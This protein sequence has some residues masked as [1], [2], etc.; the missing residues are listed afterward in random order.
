M[1]QFT[2][3]LKK[4]GAQGEKTGWT[5]IELPAELANELMPGNKR[6]FRVKGQLDNFKIAGV[7]TIPMGGGDFIIAINATMRKAIRKSQGD[8]VTAKLQLDKQEVA[9]SAD[10]MACLQDEPVAL[11]HFKS[12]PHSHQNYFTRWIESAKTEGTKAKRIAQAIN[13]LTIGRQFGEVIS[14]IKK[15][16]EELG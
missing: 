4:L 6:S 5:I 9:P 1:I 13:G 14:E 3:T 12:L 16:K 10:L 7:A 8:V 2:A 11:Q 15:Q